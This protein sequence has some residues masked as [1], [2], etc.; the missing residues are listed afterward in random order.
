MVCCN[1][2]IG[3]DG[4][5]S[6]YKTTS[7]GDLLA[8]MIELFHTYRMEDTLETLEHFGD[9]CLSEKQF[10]QL[11]GKARLY[12]YLPKKVKKQ[13]PELLYGESHFSTIAKDYYSDKSFCKEESGNINLWRVYNLLTG[14]N[15]SSYIDTFLSRG[16]N[17]FEFTQGL[18]KAISGDSIYRWFLS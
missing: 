2:C 14:A 13:L 18:S 7:I 8:G 12:N 15:K 11:V 10:A 9:R 3:T 1:L 17:A 4:F 16:V 5:K 6:D